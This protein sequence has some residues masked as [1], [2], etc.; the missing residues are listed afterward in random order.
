MLTLPK[1]LKYMRAKDQYEVPSDPCQ[2]ELEIM[3]Q[4]SLHLQNK[5]ALQWLGMELFLRC[6]S[7]NKTIRKSR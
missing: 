4:I 1:G 7:A 2:F 6:M 5:I 3:Q